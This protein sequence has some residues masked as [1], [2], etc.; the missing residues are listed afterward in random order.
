MG[1]TGQRR[2]AAARFVFSQP[3]EGRPR[4]LP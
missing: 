1:S 2:N 3:P 4:H